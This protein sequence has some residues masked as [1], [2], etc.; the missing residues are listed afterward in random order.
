[1]A[2]IE[3]FRKKTI[4]HSLILAY[5]RFLSNYPQVIRSIWVSEVK[6]KCKKI[7]SFT[8]RWQERGCCQPWMATLLPHVSPFLMSSVTQRH[9]ASIAIL[10]VDEEMHCLTQSYPQIK[11]KAGSTSSTRICSRFIQMHNGR[12]TMEL[13]SVRQAR[14]TVPPHRL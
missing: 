6:K 13:R 2:L 3:F 4:K 8:C 9:F 10:H 5:V 7:W 1:M 12:C 11:T 14:S